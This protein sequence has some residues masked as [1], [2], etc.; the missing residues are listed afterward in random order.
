VVPAVSELI[1]DSEERKCFTFCSARGYR[2]DG[3]VSRLSPSPRSVMD[4][5]RQLGE[6]I[7]MFGCTTARTNI[8]VAG[9]DAVELRCP[10]TNRFESTLDDF[11]S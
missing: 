3:T 6:P 5:H 8:I 10:K 11:S 4:S 1:G 7:G 2:T 9:I